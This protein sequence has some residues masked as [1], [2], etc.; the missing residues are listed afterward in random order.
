MTHLL[1]LSSTF[2]TFPIETGSLG[3][4]ESLHKDEDTQICTLGV[5][6]SLKYTVQLLPA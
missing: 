5:E 4:P 3:A 6:A 2:R 1:A